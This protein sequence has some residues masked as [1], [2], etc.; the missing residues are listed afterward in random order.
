MCLRVF[1]RSRCTAS[2][3]EEGTHV[4]AAVSL[5]RCAEVQCPQCAGVHV[6]A[7]VY[8]WYCFIR[9]FCAVCSAPCECFNNRII[10]ESAMRDRGYEEEKKWRHKLEGEAFACSSYASISPYQSL[11]MQSSALNFV[12]LAAPS[13]RRISLHCAPIT[14]PRCS[15]MLVLPI[16]S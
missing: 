12:F 13:T 2:Y 6:Q 15:H 8:M 14:Q 5:L 3:E 9:I 10:S 1:L 11:L 16:V 4:H 7:R